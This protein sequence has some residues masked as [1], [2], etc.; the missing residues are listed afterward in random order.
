MSNISTWDEL[1]ATVANTDYLWIG[2]DLDFNEIQPSGFSSTV[3]IKGNID[4]NGA[5][6]FNFR[7]MASQA[8]YQGSNSSASYFKN[9][10]FQ[11]IEHMPSSTNPAVFLAG[12]SGKTN[13]VVVTGTVSGNCNRYI[14]FH[15]YYSPYTSNSNNRIDEVGC[16][17]SAQLNCPFFVF[18]DNNSSDP[19]TTVTRLG[20][21]DCRINLDVTHTGGRPFPFNMY[22]CKIDGSIETTNNSNVTI[23]AFCSAISLE[24]NRTITCPNTNVV[25]SD[26]ATYESNPRLVLCDSAF[27]NFKTEIA[28]SGFPYNGE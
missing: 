28:E 5:T 26:L 15:H 2:G 6:F 13:N 14:L 23:N 4:F 19:S 18:S 9:I 1:L 10:T 21:Y 8:I 17:I 12:L 20:I 22:N 27:S 11:N 24:S 25:R 3:N 16:D 7:S